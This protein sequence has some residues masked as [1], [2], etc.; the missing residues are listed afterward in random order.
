MAALDSSDNRW[1]QKL[2]LV[3]LTF[4]A[5]LSDAARAAYGEPAAI[6]SAV[7]RDENRAAE[8]GFDI[9]SYQID[10]TRQQEGVSP[11]QIVHLVESR[12]HNYLDQ[13]AN[14]IRR[15]TA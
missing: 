15:V 2:L 3:G 1:D 13:A 7:R 6:E 14:A 10:P 4:T 5:T 8:A 12:Q 9:T 11:C